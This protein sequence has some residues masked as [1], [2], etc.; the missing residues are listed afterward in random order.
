MKRLAIVMILAGL[1][2]SGNAHAWF[3]FFIPGSATRAIGDAITG[4]KGNICVKEGTQ[5]GQILTANNGNTAKVISTSGTSSICQNPA[6]PIRAE[7]EFTYDFSSKAGIDLPD[8]FQPTTL[9]D[10]DRFNGMLLKATSKNTKN[11]GIQISSTT[12]KQNLD[13]ETMANNLERAILN[14]QKL[15]DI[16]SA[17]AEKLTVNGMP[18]VRFEISGTLSGIFGQRIIYQ[19]TILEG[20]KEMVVVDVYAP[21][22]YMESNRHDLQKMAELVS[23][24]HAGN[25]TTPAAVSVRS[26]L[27]QATPEIATPTAQVQAESPQT[28]P[29]PSV[30][31]ITDPAAAPAVDKS[32]S[33][34]QRL[35]RLSKL[36]KDGVIT[37]ADFDSKKQ[38]IL[39]DL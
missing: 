28:A 33:A 22:D 27:P 16:T 3:F 10:L 15:K 9:T 17:K 6:L 5:V 21:V 25:G 11:H 36:L 23:G 20:D 4:A 29:I 37:Q 24:L 38:E 35:Q 34:T 18:A 12:K 13:I 19:Y 26:Q 31:S 1:T 32:A 2:F 8:E 39:K 30:P 7:L 14:G